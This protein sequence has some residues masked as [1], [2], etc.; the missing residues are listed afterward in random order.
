MNERSVGVLY[1]V[2]TPIGNLADMSPRAVEILRRVALIAAEDTRHSL[3]LLRHFGIATPL[4]ALHEHNED[5]QSPRLVERLL[6]GEDIALISDAGT[7]LVSDPGFPLVRLA[8]AAGVRVSPVPGPC[9]AVVALSASGLS[10]DRFTFA[11][12]PP[13]RGPARREWLESL[14]ERPETLIF[15]ESGHRIGDFLHDLGAVFP[16]SR[17]VVV[18]RELTK[19]HETVYA[20]TAGEAAGWVA[21]DA[22]R[23]KGEFVVL[24]GGAEL[25]P[26]G[27]DM[28]AEAVRVLGILLRGGCSVKDASALAA[29]I[30][31]SRRRAL[32]TRAL[33]LAEEID[34]V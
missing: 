17:P 2:A 20:T 9:A 25:Q 22:D 3:P 5:V 16:L 28:D 19:L 26:G 34:H 11:G 1:L 30:T 31:G 15:Y 6:A 4:R 13:R 12:F 33:R 10:C 8:R 21:A 7:P 27:E 32:Y 23:R 24:V 29:E 18:A 14:C